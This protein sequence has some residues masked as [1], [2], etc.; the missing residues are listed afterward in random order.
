[1]LTWIVKHLASRPLEPHDVTRAHLAAPHVLE[2]W[3]T[4]TARHWRNAFLG[5]VIGSLV[6]LAG[7]L[8]LG[9]TPGMVLLALTTDVATLW[10]CDA[11]KWVLARSRV[12]EE[13]AHH[14]E[15]GDVLA[16]I[17]ALRRPRLPTQRDLLARSPRPQLLL[18]ALPSQ[19]DP[20]SDRPVWIGMT[21]FA[22]LLFGFLV[23]RTAPDVAPW[24]A[25]AALL[26]LAV[27]AIRTRQA[28]RDAG[29]RPDLLPEAGIPTAVLCLA[30][31]PSFLILAELN[32]ELAP[33]GRESLALL[34]LGLHLA[35][36]AGLGMLGLRRIGLATKELREFVARDLVQL[37][38]RVRQING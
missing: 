13:R 18:S 14:Q 16:V 7:C 1:M 26:R 29:P 31:Y 37:Q 2:A 3:Q 36:A 33:F 24:L 9:W 32:P 22:T 38:Q 5:P 17:H 34:L 35:V 30:L 25:V 19:L 8:V 6:P 21:L 10:L 27:C 20:A 12:E 28:R 4:R 15:A 23:A 11:M